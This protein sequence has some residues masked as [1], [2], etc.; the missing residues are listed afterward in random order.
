MMDV[1]AFMAAELN[2]REHDVEVPELKGFFGK[3][4]PVWRV[5]G[6]TANEISQANQA[7]ERGTEDLKAVIEAFTGEG[8]EKAEALRKAFGISDGEVQSDVSRRIAILMFGSVS[9]KLGSESEH[10]DFVLRIA[11]HFPTIFYNLTT[12][13]LGL[14]G[15]GSEVGKLKRSGKGKT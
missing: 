2:T 13:I 6:L 4:K 10:R 9:P 8:S 14:T 3:K 7:A 1:A 5:R 15:E 12:T 11:E